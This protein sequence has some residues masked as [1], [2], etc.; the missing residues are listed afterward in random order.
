MKLAAILLIFAFPVLAN[1]AAKEAD[2]SKMY[3]A[4]LK[5]AGPINNSVVY[6]CSEQV[7]GAAKKEIN[8]LYAKLHKIVS[9]RD[10]S[11]AEKLEQTQ[12]AWIAYR[13]GQCELATSYIGSP[14]YGY[15]PMQMNIQRV[16]E[17]KELLGSNE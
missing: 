9:Q 14:M 15:C 12:K 7:S 6:G 11:D 4:C 13:N 10:P 8:S 17:L 1:A 3:D 16:D 2:Y 5:E